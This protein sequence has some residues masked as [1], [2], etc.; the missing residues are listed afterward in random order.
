MKTGGRTRR[1]SIPL[2]E[3]RKK[4]LREK[5]ENPA[6]LDYAVGEIVFD[7]DRAGRLWTPG[8]DRDVS[9]AKKELDRENPERS[10]EVFR[11]RRR[12]SGNGFRILKK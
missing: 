1:G 5:L 2:T 4:E 6:Y 10:E 12:V 3:E 9:Q 8:C 11:I 7:P